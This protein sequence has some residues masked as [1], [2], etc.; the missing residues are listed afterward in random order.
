MKLS[1]LIGENGDWAKDALSMLLDSTEERI[2]TVEKM[3][4]EEAIA[5][6]KGF[7]AVLGM[8]TDRISGEHSNQNVLIAP[9]RTALNRAT[10]SPLSGDYSQ[11]IE[12]LDLLDAMWESGAVFYLK[13]YSLRSA[14]GVAI[15]LS[16]LF[17]T[18][19]NHLSQ[20]KEM[21]VEVLYEQLEHMI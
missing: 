5:L 4:E 13:L 21:V 6:V 16:T 3:D 7:C 14:Q 8:L 9:M 11:Q 2:R 18:L 12:I 15:G 1:E 20:Q 17:E 10:K 19:I